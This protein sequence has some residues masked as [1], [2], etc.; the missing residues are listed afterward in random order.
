VPVK[1][2]IAARR[3]DLI[4]E[5]RLPGPDAIPQTLRLWLGQLV[6]RIGA[7]A[8]GIKQIYPSDSREVTELGDAVTRRYKSVSAGFRLDPLAQA[9]VRVDPQTDPLAAEKRAIMRDIDALLGGIALRSVDV[10]ET[11]RQL[12]DIVQR[13]QNLLR[14]AQE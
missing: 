7:A 14:S 11:T 8:K 4:A 9:V 12:A 6:F 1:D 5:Q 13:T 2:L 10:E 3:F